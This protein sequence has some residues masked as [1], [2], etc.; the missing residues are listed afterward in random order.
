MCFLTLFFLNFWN[1]CEKNHEN[2]LNFVAKLKVC[3][4]KTPVK[5]Y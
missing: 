5:Q 4:A 1:F 2:D 3:F